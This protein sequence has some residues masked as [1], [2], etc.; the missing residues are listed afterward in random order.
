MSH[1]SSMRGS[2][3]T[4]AL[5]FHLFTKMQNIMARVGGWH[6]LP[7]FP[8]LYQQT[9]GGWLGLFLIALWLTRKHLKGVFIQTLRLGLNKSKRHDFSKEPMSSRA[10]LIGL[11]LGLSFLILF[12]MAGGMSF[13]IAFSFFTLL[14][15]LETTVTRMRAELGPPKPRVLFGGTRDYPGYDI[16]FPPSGQEKF[17]NADLLVFY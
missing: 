17:D 2:A 11:I 14:I 8:Y 7:G 4:D 16:G 6:S 15:A 3:H 12:C 1:H 10:A 9:T 13:W 5:A